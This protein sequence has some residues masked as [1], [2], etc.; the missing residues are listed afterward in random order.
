MSASPATTYTG[1]IPKKSDITQA[2]NQVFKF[3]NFLDCLIGDIRGNTIAV[4]G[5]I[6]SGFMSIQYLYAPQIHYNLSG[7]PIVLG[8][9]PIR[10]AS[11]A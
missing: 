3:E 5:T 2:T 11:S 8:I 4:I 1:S 9:C 10:K 6:N 7:K